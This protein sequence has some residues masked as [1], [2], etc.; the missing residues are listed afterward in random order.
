L[1]SDETGNNLIPVYLQQLHLSKEKI[2]STQALPIL[3]LGSTGADV[4]YLQQ[5]LNRINYGPLVADGI[6]GAKTEAAVKRFQKAFKLT[7]DGIVG[8]QT[9]SALQSQID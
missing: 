1:T 4:K 8:P 6:F 7:V 3:R 5:I 2:M 9:W